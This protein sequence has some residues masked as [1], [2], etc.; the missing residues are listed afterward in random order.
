MAKTQVSLILDESGSMMATIDQTISGFNEYVD[1][2]RDQKGVRFTLTKFNTNHVTIVHD[3]EKLKNVGK[4]SRENYKPNYATPLLDAVGKTVR[5][6]EEK[7][8]KHR[9]LVIVLTDGQENS[10]TEFSKEAIK[11]LVEEKEEQGWKFVFLGADIDAFGEAWGI[12][13]S[14][15]NTMGYTSANTLEMY[16]GLSGATRSYLVSTD[17]D[18]DFFESQVK[19]A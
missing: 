2:L 12:G 6:L 8:K 15:G 19:T 14:K 4:L 5:A 13:I 17:N 18:K 3:G 7:S 16:K 1:S 11:K 10:S 9:K